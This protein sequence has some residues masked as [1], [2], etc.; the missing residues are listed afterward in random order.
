M[1]LA[2]I[3][4]CAA[5]FQLLGNREGFASAKDLVNF[6]GLVIFTSK[7]CPHCQNFQGTVDKLTKRYKDQ[8]LVVDSTDTTDS[9]VSDLMTKYKVTSVPT[10]LLFNNGSELR[11][12]NQ[13]EYDDLSKIIEGLGSD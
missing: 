3:L 9:E 4:V 10:V 7:N 2:V 12:V 13:R 5:L 8:V 1:L 6:S 11:V